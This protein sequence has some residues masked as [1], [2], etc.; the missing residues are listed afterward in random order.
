VFL[1]ESLWLQ[2]GIVGDFLRVIGTYTSRRKVIVGTEK[3]SSST[4]LPIIFAKEQNIE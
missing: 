3:K 4:I 2:I 1:I